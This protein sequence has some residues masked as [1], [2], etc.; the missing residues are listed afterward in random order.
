MHIGE[1]IRK[2]RE[3]LGIT[4]VELSQMTGISS[5]MLQR[6]EA[7]NNITSVE[8]A[9]KIAKALHTTTEALL[10]DK[11]DVPDPRDDLMQ[12]AQAVSALLAGGKIPDEDRAEVMR[13]IIEAV[14]K[15]PGK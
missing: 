8:A 2:L 1:K 13:I 4:Q 14:T 15:T 9:R 5:R 11:E 3:N 12:H 10:S 7:G 6:Y